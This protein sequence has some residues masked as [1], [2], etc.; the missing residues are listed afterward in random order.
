VSF[1][2]THLSE[3]ESLPV[4][5]HGLRWH[6]I[7][8]RLDIRAFGVNAWSAEP[9]GELIEEH[10]ESS[11]QHEELYVVLSG[12]ATFTVDG[13]AVDAPAGTLVHLPEPGVRRSAVAAEPGTTVLAIGAKPGEAFTVSGWEVARRAEYLPPEEG[14]RLVEEYVRDTAPHPAG[15]YNLACFRMR[16]G[17]REGALEAFRRAFELDAERVREWARADSDLDPIRDEVSAITG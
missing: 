13:E 14:V 17:D 12:R 11:L 2:V 15:F 16:A 4:G 6:P 10:T 3:L 7:R 8:S 1:S 5:E 9:G